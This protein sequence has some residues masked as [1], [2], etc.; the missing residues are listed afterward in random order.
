M[1]LLGAALR[2]FMPNHERHARTIELTATWAADYDV[3]LADFWM[4]PGCGPSVRI[5]PDSDYSLEPEWLPVSRAAF[6]TLQLQFELFR[7]WEQPNF[8]RE[9][10]VP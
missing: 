9:C 10:S 4:H 5:P 6:P 3:D 7:T 1:A 8:F 2:I